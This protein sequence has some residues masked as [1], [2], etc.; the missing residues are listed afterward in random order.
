MGWN[1]TGTM[2]SGIIVWGG[3]GYVLDRWLETRIFTLVGTI[4]GLTVAIYLIVVKY[5]SVD[6]PPAVRRSTR[7]TSGG[8]RRRPRTQQTQKGQR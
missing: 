6:Q 2:L 3:V 5:G 4:L 1:I 8:Q 7:T